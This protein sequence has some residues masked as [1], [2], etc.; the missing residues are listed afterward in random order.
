MSFF[1]RF[2]KG[3][4]PVRNEYRVPDGLLV[5]AIGDIHGRD[6]LFADLI[7]R[8]DRDRR[9]RAHERCV[10][11]LLGDLV[12]RGPE[13]AAVVERAI[14]LR[15]H[16]DHVH[17]LIG[18]HEECMLAALSGDISALRY[19]VRIGG[20]A[21][22]RSY[23]GDDA[24]YER[25]EFDELSGIFR[26]RVPQSHIDFLGRG[27]DLVQ[28]GDYAF[29]HAGIREN[30]PLEKQKTSD[31]RWIREHFLK[32]RADHGA[33]VVHGHTISPDVEEMANRVG[34]DTGAY[35]TGRLTSLCLQGTERSFLSTVQARTDCEAE[36]QSPS[37]GASSVALRRASHSSRASPSK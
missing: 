29:V 19:F 8:I 25:L 6:D 12:D 21:T 35:L 11:I 18:N 14:R 31:L 3:P 34:I 5:Y 9:V 23:L 1:A 30:V 22:V 37:H 26:E 27:E 10:L 16:F 24:L 15:T 7:D 28:Y 17:H 2:R 33:I 36:L 20:D 32:S 4:A 13:S